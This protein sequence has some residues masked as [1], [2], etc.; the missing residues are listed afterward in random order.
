MSKHL[1][2][3]PN[4]NNNNKNNN[5]RARAVSSANEP[6][7]YD[8]S[9]ESV[10]EA[11]EDCLS[12]KRGSPDFLQYLIDSQTDLYHLHRE[13]QAGVY[14][15]EPSRSFVKSWPVYRE[16]FAAQ[17][18]DRI[19]HH[20]WASRVNPLFEQR[21]FEIGDVAKNCRK[22]QGQL[23]A[24]K[25]A[26]R[27]ISEH[28][29]WWIGHFDIEA[30]FIS[31]DKPL[32]FEMLDIF[33]RENYSGEDIEVLLFVTRKLVFNAPQANATRVGPEYLWR[34]VP[35]HKSLF[36]RP[37]E[38]GCAIGNLPSQLNANFIGSVLDKWITQVK[39]VEN[40]IRFSDDILIMLPD[41]KSFDLLLP[42]LK[43]FLE[44]QLLLNLHPR[45][46][47]IQP[48]RKGVLFV[49]AMIL[50]G[51]T[52]ISNR[53]RG[54]MYDKLHYYNRLAENGEALQ[55]LDKFVQSMNS[56]LG[57]T[58]HHKAYNV[59]AKFVEH[60][61]PVW[62]Q[63]VYMS[64]GFKTMVIK[65]QYRHREILKQM[66]RGRGYCSILTPELL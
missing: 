66:V 57:M 33:I 65:K 10:V 17:F 38:K 63:Y 6:I 37:S 34:N 23:V 2:G 20:W 15:P 36:S 8:I 49:G 54:R 58:I 47:Y 46:I 4:P 9:F 39:G 27:M 11:F 41:R 42:E 16:I 1:T 48:A 5:N 35:K 40:Y 32:L 21:H 26:A 14:E 44:S 64:A 53:T 7:T 52:Y 61:S 24:V 62:W 13:V 43:D 55:Y 45:K 56:Y 22:G 28:P 30:F 12:N 51:R 18:R 31:I 60:I 3:G 25:E 59:R 29:D 19:M 50:P